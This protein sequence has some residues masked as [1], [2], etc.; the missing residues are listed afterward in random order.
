MKLTIQQ[1]KALAVKNGYQV[2]NLIQEAQLLETAPREEFAP[3][4]TS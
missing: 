3:V 4:P 1:N 2:L